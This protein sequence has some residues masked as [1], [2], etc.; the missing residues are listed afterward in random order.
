MKKLFF[1]IDQSYSCTGIAKLITIDNII[2]SLETS[3]IKTKIT[4][5]TKLLDTIEF[6]TSPCTIP[7]GLSETNRRLDQIC[8]FLVNEIKEVGEVDELIICMESPTASGNNSPDVVYALGILY[9]SIINKLEDQFF[10]VDTIFLS[11]PPTTHKSIFFGNLNKKMEK[12]VLYEYHWKEAYNQIFNEDPEE[13]TTND[14]KDAICLA[15][16]GQLIG[17]Y[18]YGEYPV[19]HENK[20][21]QKQLKNLFCLNMRDKKLCYF[22]PDYEKCNHESKI[23]KPAS[24]AGKEKLELLRLNIFKKFSN[25][26]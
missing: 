19:I 5:P 4:P 9:Y 26:C 20:E 17:N 2:D 6:L 22:C 7:Y 18:N 13:E 8:K 14:E 16:C 15:F 11:I 1:G 24:K 23:S 10:G 12:A 25:F 3:H 21:V